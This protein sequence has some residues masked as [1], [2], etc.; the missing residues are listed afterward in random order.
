MKAVPVGKVT[1]SIPMED[2]N[3]ADTGLPSCAGNKR[4]QTQEESKAKKRSTK[5]G[6]FT[7]QGRRR[8]HHLDLLHQHATNVLHQRFLQFRRIATKEHQTVMTVVPLRIA[9]RRENKKRQSTPKS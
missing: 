7:K 3:S 1:E 5:A 6:E 2:L 9:K 4:D 8:H